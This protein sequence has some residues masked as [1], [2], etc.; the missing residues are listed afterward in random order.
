VKNL[1]N[2]NFDRI[3]RICILLNI[4]IYIQKEDTDYYSVL[5]NLIKHQIKIGKLYKIYRI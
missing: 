4:V 3:N 1:R 5:K 2:V